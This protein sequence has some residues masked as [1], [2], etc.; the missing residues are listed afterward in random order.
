MPKSKRH[1][2]Y[3]KGLHFECMG[4]GR[5][6]SGPGEGYIWVTR[7][8]IQIIADFLKITPGQLRQKYLRRVGFRATI[9][10]QPYTRDCIFL[11]EAGGQRRCT[12]YAVRP[13]Q[14]R[15]WPFWPD[16]LANSNGWN[17]AAQRCPGINRGKFYSFDEIQIIKKNRKW[18]QDVKQIVGS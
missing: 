10:E 12:I 14:C 3:T 6:C 4:C 13:S 5:C 11:Q 2:W 1:P 8:E 18:W 17:K 7:P 9:I 16:N 15:L